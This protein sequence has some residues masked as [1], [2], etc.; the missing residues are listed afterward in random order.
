MIDIWGADH[1]GYVPR[2]KAA[3]TALPPHEPERLELIIGQFVNLLE[4]GET[5]AHVE[6]QGDDR[7][8]RRP[9]RRHRRRRDALH[10]GLTLAR[11]APR[12]RPRARRASSRARTPCTTC[13]T[14]TRA[15]AASCAPSKRGRGSAAPTRGSARSAL[16]EDE[17]ALVLKLAR[18]PFVVLAPPSSGRRIAST[19]I[20]ASWRRSSTS[21]TGTAACS[22][23]TRTSRRSA[24]G[25][26]SPPGRRWRAGLDLLG[27]ERP[28]G[29]VTATGGGA[30][31]RRPPATPAAVRR[32]VRRRSALGASA[33]LVH[34]L[35]V[36]SLLE[37]EQVRDGDVALAAKQRCRRRCRGH[38]R[39]L[40]ARDRRRVDV[41]DV[42]PVLSQQTLLDEVVHDRHD[43]GVGDLA[44]LAQGLVHVADRGALLLPDD[45]EDVGLERPDAGERCALGA[46]QPLRLSRLERSPWELPLAV[47]PGRPCTAGRTDTYVRVRRCHDQ[48]GRSSNRRSSTGRP[49]VTGR[50]RERR[51]RL[52]ES[53]AGAGLRVGANTSAG[54]ARRRQAT[55]GESP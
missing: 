19:P 2:M 52:L 4:G 53:V 44:A 1:H 9:H 37:A 54:R 15:S 48:N 50:H 7:H 8:G 38:L 35:A 26:A 12:H 29:D 45:G 36:S 27:V 25:S 46:A 33:E 34:L 23:T 47:S 6:A 41:G 21:S 51:R 20:S 40:A 24:P 49:F 3:F 5:E 18:F 55:R 30:E 14:R 16:E 43:R 31:R 10:H 42:G 39:D 17:R 32:A 22:S 11:H 13:S 28:R